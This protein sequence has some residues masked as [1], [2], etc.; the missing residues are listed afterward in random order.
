MGQRLVSESKHKGHDSPSLA[1]PSTLGFQEAHFFTSLAF[2]CGVPARRSVLLP[3]HRVQTPAIL[4]PEMRAT[5]LAAISWITGNEFTAFRSFSHGS[6]LHRLVFGLY[7]GGCT[8]MIGPGAEDS[9]V[10]CT[11]TPLTSKVLLSLCGNIVTLS[12]QANWRNRTADRDV[13]IWRVTTEA[14]NAA[15]PRLKY[16]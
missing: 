1:Q 15:V 4:L 6:I 9:W 14:L 5:S 16:C 8:K 7:T 2:R 10:F 11:A 3:R 13:G 12:T